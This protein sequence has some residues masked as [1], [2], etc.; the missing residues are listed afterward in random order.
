MQKGKQ[1]TNGQSGATEPRD[2]LDMYSQILR[3]SGDN[4]L[5]ENTNLGLGNYDES[6]K[7][8]Q[9]RS[10]RKG[11]YAYVAFSRILTQRAI[12]ETK[13]KLAREGF[14]HYNEQKD[15]VE[16]WDSFNGT[17][18]NQSRWVA[19]M[20]RG[21]SIWEELSSP[22]DALSTKQVAAIIKKTGISTE[23]VPIYWQM[24]SGRHEVSRSQDAELIRDLLTGI[25][26]LREDG[27]SDSSGSLFGGQ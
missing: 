4:P 2:E 24:V 20:E 15:K 11:L 17:A 3:S 19:E 12:H 27:G 7:W 9:I 26:H 1:Q 18:E 5:L 21:E 14:S 25:K 16:Q 22:R 23:W 6:Y 10:Y 8:Q 13:V